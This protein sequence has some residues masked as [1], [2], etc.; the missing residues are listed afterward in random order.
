[1]CQLCGL[2]AATSW[3]FTAAQSD[4]ST[5]ANMHPT[6][7]ATTITHNITTLVDPSK[8]EK[9]EVQNLYLFLAL[10]LDGN[11]LR[12]LGPVGAFCRYEASRENIHG[13]RWCGKKTYHRLPSSGGK[14]NVWMLKFLRPLLRFFL[15]QAWVSDAAAELFGFP[16][17][18]WLITGNIFSHQ[19]HSINVFGSKS[20]AVSSR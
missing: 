15:L 10:G 13:W 12:G 5:P 7:R 3:I 19:Y 2:I 9:S 17:R 1:M 4:T 6:Q 16:K 11:S 14:V 20:C 18:I 8:R